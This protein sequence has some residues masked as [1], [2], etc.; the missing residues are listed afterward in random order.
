MFDL[1]VFD[2][3]NLSLSRYRTT[4]QTVNMTLTS[5]W[6]RNIH[7]EK[8]IKVTMLLPSLYVSHHRRVTNWSVDY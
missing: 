6:I 2:G 3:A 4:Q 7:N 5:L 8:L 1:H